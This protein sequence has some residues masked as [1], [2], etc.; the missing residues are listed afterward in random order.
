MLS[1]RARTVPRELPRSKASYGRGLLKQV[2]VGQM[3]GQVSRPL[4]DS[5]GNQR[6]SIMTVKMFRPCGT[7]R[8]TIS[9]SEPVERRVA[10]AR[11]LNLQ[12]IAERSRTPQAS[13]E[14]GGCHNGPPCRSQSRRTTSSV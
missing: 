14:L 11:T 9:A 3:Q 4:T 13:L 6:R 7:R 5:T 2:S 12:G 8:R 1:T 10:R